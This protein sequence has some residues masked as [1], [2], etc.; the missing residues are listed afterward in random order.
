MGYMTRECVRCGAWFTPIHPDECNA[1]AR[2]HCGSLVSGEGPVCY[3][4][5]DKADA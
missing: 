3:P 5:L 1:A 4:C 2:P